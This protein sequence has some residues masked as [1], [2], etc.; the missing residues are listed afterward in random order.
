MGGND[1]FGEEAGDAVCAR[2]G[3]DGFGRAAHG[4]RGRDVFAYRTPTAAPTLPPSLDGNQDEEY[5][6]TVRTYTV[7]GPSFWLYDKVEGSPVVSAAQNS[8]LTLTEVIDPSTG[9]S[10]K[11]YS[12][13]Y[14]NRTYYVPGSAL[15]VAYNPSTPPSYTQGKTVTVYIAH[16]DKDVN[17]TETGTVQLYT[18]TALKNEATNVMLWDEQLL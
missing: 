18:D 9:K 15:D 14:K 3:R 12:T 13:W 6:G 11:W 16:G 10:K 4:D 7:T 1:G 17:G 2:F 8:V 5:A